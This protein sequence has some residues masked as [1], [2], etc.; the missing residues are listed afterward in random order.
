[1]AKTFLSLE[2]HERKQLCAAVDLPRLIARDGY[3]ITERGRSITTAFRPERT[4][5]VSLTLKDGCW[6]W[7]DFGSREGGD[8]LSYLCN[9]RGLPFHEALNELRSLAGVS[10]P[11]Y[12]ATPAKASSK[13]SKLVQRPRLREGADEEVEA[14]AE[15]R[16]VSVW[17]VNTLQSLDRLAFGVWEGESAFFIHSGDYQQARRLNGKPWFD[18][19]GFKTYTIGTAP[20]WIGANLKPANTHV[21]VVEGPVGILEAVEAFHRTGITACCGFIGSY[22][23]S[24]RLTAAQ[25]QR[26]A[27][28]KVL[29]VSDNDD[30]G[31]KASAA[32]EAAI[33]TFGGEVE[34]VVPTVGKDLGDVLKHSPDP[35]DAFV[36]FLSA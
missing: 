15:L 1:M 4:P 29:I 31:L 2:K 36:R 16:G 28:H 23:S 26:L 30:G 19:E 32:W 17:A 34:R 24:S 8:V 21:V 14:L 13:P 3:I 27:G 5:S 25:A 20:E 33:L 7:F 9:V 10:L 11:D 6:M 18:R 22:N 35:P 12:T